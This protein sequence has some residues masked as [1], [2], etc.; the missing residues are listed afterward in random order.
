M[1]DKKEY[2]D[3]EYLSE[4]QLKLYR[5]GKMTPLE[6]RRVESLLEKYPLYAEALEGLGLLNEKQAEKHIAF[7]QENIQAKIGKN[8]QTKTVFLSRSNLRRIAAAVIVLIVFSFG[9]YF[10]SSQINKE[11]LTSK[12]MAIEENTATEANTYL[13]D[14]AQVYSPL[15][16]EESATEMPAEQS[17]KDAKETQRK[18]L[19][20]KNESKKHIEGKPDY[21]P[22]V[23]EITPPAPISNQT[24]VQDSSLTV[25]KKVES[26]ADDDLPKSVPA[27]VGEEKTVQKESEPDKTAIEKERKKTEANKTSHEIIGRILPPF[28]NNKKSDYTDS[29]KIHLQNF[30]KEKNVILKGKLS[31]TFYLNHLYQVQN[32]TVKESPCPSCESETIRWIQEYKHWQKYHTGLQSI[33]IVFD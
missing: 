8:N 9:L 30:A 15:L 31:V 2:I 28:D 12:E 5:E 7:L 4:H 18:E 11:I 26:P 1:K 27:K 32:I 25:L 14:S 21:A 29:L 13:A 17:I 3:K 19:A 10:I 23:T 6:M 24:A 20:L 22:L 16:S 33:E